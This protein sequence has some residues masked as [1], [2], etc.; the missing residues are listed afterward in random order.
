M[1]VVAFANKDYKTTTTAIDYKPLNR[2]IFILFAFVSSLIAI[3]IMIMVFRIRYR[4]ILTGIV[5]TFLVG[6]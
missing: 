5:N 2:A 6:G 4:S 3:G 1:V